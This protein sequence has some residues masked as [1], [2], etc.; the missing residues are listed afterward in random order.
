MIVTPT[1]ELHAICRRWQ[2][3]EL[4]IFGSALRD[5]FRTDSDIDLLVTFENGAAWSTL[6]LVD[7]QAEFAEV[8][9]RPVDLVEKAT[10]RNPFRRKSILANHRVLYAA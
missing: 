4:S 7:L 1:T 10:L 9:G 2:I 5:D 8:F 3:S 6:D